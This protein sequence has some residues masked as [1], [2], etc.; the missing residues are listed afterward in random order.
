MSE[1][2]PITVV[3]V[4]GGVAGL[5]AAKELADNRI[6]FVLLEAQ[7]YLGG[8]VRTI[9]A[10]NT[11]RLLFYYQTM[12]FFQ[13]KKAPDLHIDLGAQY[14]LGDTNNV[15]HTICK[16]LNC[17]ADQDEKED[18]YLSPDGSR[19]EDKFIEKIWQIR[20]QILED[21]QE[22]SKNSTSQTQISLLQHLKESY[23]QKLNNSVIDDENLR[24]ALIVWLL[25]LE[26]VDI[27]CQNL[28]DVRLARKYS[29]TTVFQNSA[30]I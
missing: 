20:E 17:I 27:G 18:L 23:A 16:Q 4:G 11:F 24:G 21:A 12:F 14:I 5:S 29:M 10:G 30:A 13:S 7:D 28:N 3:I 8:R 9:E 22:K 19:L 15:V 26:E 6:D 1:K 25:K 2:N